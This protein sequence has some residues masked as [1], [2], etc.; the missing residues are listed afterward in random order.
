MKE[1]TRELESMQPSGVMVDLLLGVDVENLADDQK[2]TLLIAARKAMAA[3]HY[4]ELSLVRGIEDTAEIAMAIREPEQSV[5]RQKEY[6]DVLDRL[7][8]CAELLR[9]GEI[10]PRRLKTVDDRVVHLTDPELISQV[11]EA[12][13]DVAPGLTRTQ[14]A[15]RATKAAAEADPLGYDQ[16]RLKARE[17]RRVEFTPLPDGMAQ[18]SIVLPAI[19]ARQAY[20]IL[21][22]DAR[23]LPKDDRTTDQKRADAFL[24]R[25]LG[26]GVD[27]KVQVHVTISLETLM[28][29]TEDPGL[30]D[31]YGPIAADSSRELAMHGP[32]RGLLLDEYD[33]ADALSREKYRPTARIKEFS[34]LS[35]GGVCSAPG[36][37]TPIQ[38]IDHTIPWPQGKTNAAQLKGYCAH[39]HHLKH[40]DYTVTLNQDGTLHWRTPL[41]RHY[42]TQPHQY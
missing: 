26:Y 42:T 3:L 4:V 11:D 13:A 19:D 35:A 34:E 21:T 2:L 16:R 9:R 1:I 33:R 39:H 32:W 22:C 15:R 14:L 6:S 23:S 40:G 30:L 41:G 38:E 27:R 17:D 5:V 29:L 12:L 7:P 20:D 31:G 37:T 8:R 36:C 28:G 18:L 10:D 24:D 25:F